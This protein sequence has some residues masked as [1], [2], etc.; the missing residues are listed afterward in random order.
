MILGS[1]FG[2]EQINDPLPKKCLD[3]TRELNDYIIKKYDTPYCPELIDSY[4]FSTLS[5]K[6]FCTALVFDI[7][8]CFALIME[9]ECNIKIIH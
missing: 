3:L 2:R 7:I 8:D 6:G 9:R 1:I 5:R 4:D